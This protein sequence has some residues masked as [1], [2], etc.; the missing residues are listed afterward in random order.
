MMNSFVEVQ[1]SLKRMSCPGVRHSV[2]AWQSHAV[3]FSFKPE[4]MKSPGLKPIEAQNAR[5]A[6]L[7]PLSNVK[8]FREAKS[9]RSR[10]DR[11]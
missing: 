4:V 5:L 11:F 8:F 10:Q 1:N 7:W 9:G 3:G 6:R 2:K